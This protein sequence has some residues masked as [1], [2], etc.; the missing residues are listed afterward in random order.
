MELFNETKEPL[1]HLWSDG[2]KRQA[3]KIVFATA[4]GNAT[5]LTVKEAQDIM[6]E[7]DNLLLDEKEE[8]IKRI[9]PGL[10]FEVQDVRLP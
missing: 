8:E 9:S 6:A 7:L 2:D 1:K 5:Q 3:A 4:I 10:W